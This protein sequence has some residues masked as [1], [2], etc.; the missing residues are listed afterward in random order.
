MG[1]IGNLISKGVATAATKSI[2]KT[3]GSTTVE[4][5]SA[6]AQKQTQKDDAIEKSGKLYIK[7][8]RSSE[9]YIGENAYDIV[10]ELLGVGFESVTL[11][12][13]NKLSERAIKK[14]GNVKSIS[15]NGNCEFLGIKRVPTSSHIV[16]YFLDFKE[17]VSDTVYTNVTRLKTGK[18]SSSEDIEYLSHKSKPFQNMPKSFCQYCGEKI[19]NENAKFCSACGKEI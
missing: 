16:I 17:D 9:D 14:Y 19:L 13:I 7:P 2:I 3:V 5:I 4:V 12:S 11:K 1:L 6:T 15:I 18:I 8:T 10:Q